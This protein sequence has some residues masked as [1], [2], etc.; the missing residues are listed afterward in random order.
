MLRAVLAG[1]AFTFS[2]FVY[3]QTVTPQQVQLLA[4]QL[5]AFAGSSSNFAALVSGLSQGIPVTLLTSTLD[6]QLQVVTFTPPVVGGPTE[7]ARAL[8]AA[9]SS[10]ISRGV[11]TPSAQLIGVALMGGGLPT[12]AGAVQVPGVLTGTANLN[13]VQVRNDPAGFAGAGATAAGLNL[14]A[15]ARQGSSVTL[16]TGTQAQTFSVPGAAL[17][18]AQLQQSLLAAAQLLAQIGILNPTPQ[19]LRAALVGGPVPVAGGSVTLLGVLQ[20]RVSNTSDSPFFGTSNS[21]T[22]GTSNSPAAGTSNTPPGTSGAI[23][24]PSPDTG[25]PRGNTAEGANRAIRRGG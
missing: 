11:A 10:L 21:P 13:A 20:N 16:G 24:A 14:P 22:V 18:D 15:I 12:P 3:S 1:I 5:L 9:R 4:P 7:V 17:S 25:I 8:E 23:A 6:G 19:Q 2:S